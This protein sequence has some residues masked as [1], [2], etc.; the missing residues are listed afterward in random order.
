MRLSETMRFHWTQEEDFLNF[1]SVR[2]FYDRQKEIPDRLLE[3]WADSR[4]KNKRLTVNDFVE[5]A[6]LS[7]TQL[8]SNVIAAGVM[9]NFKL[10]EWEIARSTNLRPHWRFL[11]QLAPVSRQA[12]IE[13]NG[14]TFEQLPLGQRLLFAGLAFDT[15]HSKKEPD[16]DDL[17]GATLRVEWD[18]PDKTNK[19]AETS[20]DK[21]I[22]GGG[23]GNFTR[24][25]YAAKN[26]ERWRSLYGPFNA[27][28][29]LP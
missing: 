7:D 14:L 21:F 2:F 9:A 23:G 20:M 18:A 3:R 28:I 27:V 24:F 25:I 10:Q 1:R 19:P 8:D 29:R 4:R 5:I 13:G 22:M 6:R 11:G 26:K 16:M 17:I 15:A 12:A